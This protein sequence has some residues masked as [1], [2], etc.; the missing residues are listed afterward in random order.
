MDQELREVLQRSFLLSDA[1]FQ[2]KEEKI[3]AAVNLQRQFS[4]PDSNKLK[5]LR[6]DLNLV[7][8]ELF[9]LIDE[10]S[11]RCEI[12]EK[13]KKAKS[14]PVVG[15]PMAKQFNDTV[16]MD[17]K[18][19]SYQD[20]IWLLHL[21]DHATRY[22][23]SCVIR[24][25]RKE[26]VIEGIFKIWISI[27][28]TAGKCLVDNGDE[29]DNEDLRSMCEN[30]NIRICTSVAESPWSNGLVERHNAVLGIMFTKIMAEH[31]VHLKWQLHEQFLQ[32]IP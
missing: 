24:S 29:F 1:Q 2:S 9:K 10:I 5:S 13:Y 25:K 19:W 7:G 21:I 23:D 31:H 30:L 8:E 11:D 17:L 26:V 28:V 4:H 12:C 20:G 14:G 16:A 15:F 22:T 6:K 32:R 18:Q 27:F 3:K